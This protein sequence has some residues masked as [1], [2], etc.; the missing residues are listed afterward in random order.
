MKRSAISSNRIFG[1]KTEDS[2][3]VL[4]GRVIFSTIEFSIRLLCESGYG[5][6][7]NSGRG[8][9]NSAVRGEEG[10]I[11]RWTNCSTQFSAN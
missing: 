3:L 8:F 4:T 6:I 5:K 1:Q 11:Q 9:R 7:F 2:F 10:E